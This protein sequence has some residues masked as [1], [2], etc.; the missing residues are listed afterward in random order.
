MRREGEPPSPM[1]IRPSGLSGPVERVRRPP[2]PER[3]RV[4]APPLRRNSPE[5]EGRVD[6]PPVRNLPMERKEAFSRAKYTETIKYLARI[7]IPPRWFERF[8]C[9]DVPPARNITQDCSICTTGAMKDESWILTKCNH[10][11]HAE[12]MLGW[13]KTFNQ[14]D[15]GCPLC[16]A[17]VI[18]NITDHFFVK[19]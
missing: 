11:F 14:S 2:L 9:S 13:V 1:N 4:A 6:P 18:D 17:P 15:K 5:R 3:P 19:S 12:C 7:R 16:R 10:Y 8:C